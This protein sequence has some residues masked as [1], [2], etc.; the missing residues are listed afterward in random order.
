[1]TAADL[2]AFVETYIEA[3]RDQNAAI[4]A[5]AGLSIPAGLVNWK[6][7]LKSIAREIQLDVRKEDDLVA[8]LLGARKWGISLAPSGGPDFICSDDPVVLLPPEDAHPFFGT[9]FGTPGSI[10]CLPLSS[11]HVL[12]G[13]ELEPGRKPILNVVVIAGSDRSVASMNRSVILHSH[14][15]LYAASN[16]FVWLTNHGQLGGFKDLHQVALAARS[17]KPAEL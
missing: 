7:L 5:G 8:D 4:F 9:G 12:W 14:R 6:G 13:I 1:M 11:R 16:D 3:L 17:K 10:V 15:F 2:N